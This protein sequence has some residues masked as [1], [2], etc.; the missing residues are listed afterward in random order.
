MFARKLYNLVLLCQIVITPL[1]RTMA[2]IREHKNYFREDLR[3]YSDFQI[4]AG[5]RDNVR[6]FIDKMFN[7]EMENY[8]HFEDLCYFP[9]HYCNV[10]SMGY[11]P[12][13]NAFVEQVPKNKKAL[14][15]SST[16]VLE[17][18]NTYI[19]FASLD[20]EIKYEFIS[21]HKEFFDGL[22]YNSTIRIMPENITYNYITDN[23]IVCQ[24]A[25]CYGLNHLRIPTNYERI[26]RMNTN[27][28]D[29]VYMKIYGDREEYYT[30]ISPA[31]E[32]FWVHK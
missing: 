9:E 25:D 19:M 27:L 8:F 1:K 31:N 30:L 6:S 14:F 13:L 24:R 12:V 21:Q 10:K 28:S 23:K 4:Y 17:I 7:C 18:I 15:T 5:E 20:F 26:K 29:L 22:G 32:F 3:A 2:M 16:E 11:M